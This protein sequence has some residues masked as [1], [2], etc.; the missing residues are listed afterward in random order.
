MP[1]V[2]DYTSALGALVAPGAAGFAARQ[3]HIQHSREDFELARTLHADL[4][5]GTVAEA[6]DRLGTVVFS[7]APPVGKSVDDV[8]QAYF[9][10]LWCFERVEGERRSIADR[11]AARSLYRDKSNP[12]IAFL[13]D[14]IGW[15]VRFWREYFDTVRNWLEQQTGAEVDDKS[16]RAA[17]ERLAE[18]FP[19]IPSQQGAVAAA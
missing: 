6:R 5:T 3:A 10:L 7:K 13:D 2:G 12:A 9:T 1:N 17:F 16:S 8:R 18:H 14:V 11:H 15:H 19:E 4:T